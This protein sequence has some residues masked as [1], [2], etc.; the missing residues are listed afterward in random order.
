MEFKEFEA[1]ARIVHRSL[2]KRS[3]HSRLPED[4]SFARFLRGLHE[5]RMAKLC[6]PTDRAL[7]Q[8]L[9]EGNPAFFNTGIDFAGPLFAESG[10]TEK[11][12]KRV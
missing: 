2:P 5:D 7:P 3:Y 8:F 12:L 9:V 6:H 1:T 4:K 11:V 10:S